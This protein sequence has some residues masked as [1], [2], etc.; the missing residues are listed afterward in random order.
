MKKRVLLTVFSTLVIFGL[1]LA[2]IRYWS[3]DPYWAEVRA[4]VDTPQTY[5]GEHIDK[6]INLGPE[7]IP[8]IAKALSS[9][10]DF[11]LRFIYALERIKGKGALRPIEVVPVV[12]TRP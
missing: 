12:K 6:L 4:I 2:I 10:E 3:S 5:D 9:G 8:A 1:S 11:P 7:G